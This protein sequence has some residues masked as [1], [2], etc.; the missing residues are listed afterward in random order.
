MSEYLQTPAGTIAILV[1]GILLIA[2]APEGRLP[3]EDTAWRFPPEHS[4]SLLVPYYTLKFSNNIGRAFIPTINMMMKPITGAVVQDETLLR[5][6]DPSWNK[7]MI[8]ASM[9]VS[10]LGAFTSTQLY[11][12]TS[13]CCYSAYLDTDRVFAGCAKRGRLSISHMY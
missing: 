1:R 11:V 7:M 6:L 8:G 10:L 5:Q 4:F 3:A 2:T 9:A 13:F 12:L